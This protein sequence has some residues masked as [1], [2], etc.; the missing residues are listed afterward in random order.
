ML[1]KVIFLILNSL[2]K[3]NFFYSKMQMGKIKGIFQL[4]FF[5]TNR[6]STY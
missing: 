2:Q 3:Y 4:K 6:L 5:S 1:L